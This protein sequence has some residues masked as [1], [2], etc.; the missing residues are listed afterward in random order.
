MLLNHSSGISG[1]NWENGMGFGPDPAYNRSTLEKLAG[2]NLKF[3]PG[4]FAA[5]CNDGFTLAELVIERVSGKSF[6]EYVAQKIL[7]P[8]G[9]T[10]TGLSIGFQTAASVA[11]YYEP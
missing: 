9:M 10:H 8:L 3:A 6:I 5:Y 1:T 2:Q 7:S 11:L 4:E